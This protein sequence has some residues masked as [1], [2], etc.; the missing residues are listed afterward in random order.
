M[1][2][3]T[4]TSLS[5]GMS[6]KELRAQAGS[7]Y[8]KKNLGNGEVEYEY[9][10]RVVVSDRTFEVRHY[11]FIIKDGHV[12]SKKVISKQEDHHPLLERNAYDMQTTFK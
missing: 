11:Y 12:T 1:D 4:F 7:P 8:N 5:V 9:I 2:G 3:D 10:E 6:E